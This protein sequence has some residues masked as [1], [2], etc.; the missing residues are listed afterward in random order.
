[1]GFGDRRRRASRRSPSP[2]PCSATSAAPTSASWVG[3]LV[4]PR[5][6]DQRLRL[7]PGLRGRRVPA[8]V[9]DEPRHCP[10]T[11]G[12]AAVSPTRDAGRAAGVVAVR[13]AAIIV[14]CV[15]LPSPP[16]PRHVRLV[17]H[18]RHAD[19]ARRLRAHDD[20]RDPPG[21]RAAQ[22][23]GAACG[24]SSSRSPRCVM[25]GY[26]LYRNVIPYP[27]RRAAQWFPVVAGGW[28]LSCRVLVAPCFAG[29]GAHWPRTKAR[30][31]P[32]RRRGSPRT[33][34]AERSPDAGV[35]PMPPLLP[36]S[37]PAASS[38]TTATGSLADPS[39]GTSSRPS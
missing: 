35:R 11:R 6:G 13:M 2:R 29:A 5:R 22:D 3:D 4:T 7:L 12:P 24:R 20:R 17:G 10:A 32:G 15:A 27:T 38:T 21:V 26:T 18:H 16:R 30:R 36:A 23:A 34:A 25:L 33:R 9:R 39:T 19:P 28:L 8:A 14:V 31:T 37:R 1:M